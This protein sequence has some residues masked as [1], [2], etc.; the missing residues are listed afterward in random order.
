MNNYIITEFFA[1]IVGELIEE[2]NYYSQEFKVSAVVN[3][4]SYIITS[5][6]GLPESAMITYMNNSSKTTLVEVNILRY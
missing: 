5:K 4:D 3:V 1:Y 6:V 2:S